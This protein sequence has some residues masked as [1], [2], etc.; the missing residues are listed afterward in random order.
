VT[1]PLPGLVSRTALI[2]ACCVLTVRCSVHGSSDPASGAAPVVPVE[3]EGDGGVVHVDHPEQFLL[4]MATRHDA[5][6][7]LNVTGVVSPDVSR[8]VP[9]VSLASGRVIDLRARLGDQVRQGQLLLRIQSADVS[10]AFSDYRKARED[11]ALARTQLDRAT[12]LFDRGAV[13]R[14]DLDV[15]E[16]AANKAVVDVET[17]A[18]HLRVLGT[19]ASQTPTAIV[20]V[21]APVSGV[22]TEQNVT[23]AAGVKTLDNSPNLFTISDLSRVWIVCDVYENDLPTVRVGDTADIHLTA[24]PDRV[25]TGRTSNV[26]AAL[27]PVI[28][29]AKV[30]IEVANPGL[31]RLGMFVTATFHGQSRRSR[32]AVPDTAILHL[33]D[34]EWVYVPV[35]ATRFQRVEVVSGG[36]LPGHMQ[37]L[38]S[39][40]QPGQ[41]VVSK[42]LVLQNTVEQ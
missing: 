37:E 14:K 9:V 16:D 18:E 27:D 33:H 35:D 28:R 19:N 30:R 17:A 3:Q 31:L 7:E 24:Y 12:A 41:R 2:V 39:G 5:R 20:D 34:R 8:T 15:A 29:T 4:A 23:N 1:R 22:I 36:L 10:A 42:A 40:L 26:S 32:A 6:P 25:L 11:A 21:V 38:V 13:A